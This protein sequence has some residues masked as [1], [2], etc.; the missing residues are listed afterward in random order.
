[1]SDDLLNQHAAISDLQQTEEIVVDHHK[2]INEYLAQFLPESRDLYNMTN[3]VEYD[4]DGK[5]TLLSMF[6]VY[7]KKKTNTFYLSHLFQF[8]AYC[9]RGEEMFTELA[10][11]AIK[12]RN[13]MAEF[14][15][16]LANEEMLS[17]NVYPGKR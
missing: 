12:C 17:H 10:E 7:V 8:S 5:Q 1:M 9:K 3:S 2:A 6:D 13:L 4:Q 16:K 11:L 14:R 15:G